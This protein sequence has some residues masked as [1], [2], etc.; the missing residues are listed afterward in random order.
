MRKFMYDFVELF[1]PHL[2]PE[3]VDKAY[4][5]QTRLELDALFTNIELPMY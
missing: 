5:C 4:A 2:T 3:L 1:A